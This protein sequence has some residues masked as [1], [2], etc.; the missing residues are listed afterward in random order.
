LLLPAVSAHRRLRGPYTAA[1]TIVRGL[2]ADALT[3]APE[4]VRAHEI[5]L[6]SVAPELRDVLPA[7]KETLTSLAVPEERTRFYSRLRTLRLAHGLTEFLRDYV[8]A[9]G[10]PATLMIDQADEADQTDAELIAVL[11]RRLRP[12]SLT[13]VIGTASEPPEQTGQ[14]STALARHAVRA[15]DREQQPDG[16]SPAVSTT[17]AELAVAYVA[18]D[19]TDDEP[20][21]AAGYAALPEPERAALHDARAAELS[22]ESAAELSVSLGAV[23]YHREH[24]GDPAG[25][26]A[27]ALRKALEYCIDMGFYEATVDLGKRGRAVIDW[28]AQRD[29]WWAFTTKMTTS[30]AALSRPVEAEELYDQARAFS[31]VPSVHMQA[32][33]ATAMLYTRHH[34]A[35][36]HDDNRALAWINE[37]IAIATLL[38]DKETRAMQTV[39]HHNGLALIKTRLGQHEEALRLVSGGLQ[40]LDA[41]L[42]PDQHRLHRSVLRY[43][44]AQLY[45]AM[46]R[47]DD[48]LTDYTAVIAAD[49]NYAEYHFDRAGLL[50]KLGRDDE[51]LTEYETA[52]RLTPPFP[53]LYYNRADLLAEL[54]DIDGALADFSYVIELD[55]EQ[56][57]AY[58]NR[59][60]L[61]AGRGE[62]TAARRDVATGL[63]LAPAD[64][65]LLCLLGQLDL[66]EGDLVAARTA[67]DAAVAAG[68]GVAQTW[69]ARAAVAFESGDLV[70]AVADLTTAIELSADPATLFNRG[71]IQ[72]T[73]HQWAVAEEDFSRALRYAPDDADTW[74]RRAQ[75]RHR[76][77]DTSGAAADL[78]QFALLAPDRTAEALAATDGAT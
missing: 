27:D 21:L 12:E 77:G 51:A 68:P 31:D 36:R 30:L 14:L 2:A 8:L 73:R 42:G 44:R 43:N 69:A 10:A 72:Q 23:P 66:A 39:F 5:E 7:T 17:A 64:P 40:R 45:V 61:L 24:G 78:H 32:A 15:A 18:S 46:G 48:A 65:H 37:A 70:A 26:G 19:C 50:R 56:T 74:L 67:L 58:L 63:S 6:L 34:D 57:D 1:G 22:S 28:V 55:P 62:L 13:L 75:C 38:P 25:A 54:G 16:T 9:V 11:L 20:E 29:H 60:D 76:L 41:D 4:L 3:V 53:E 35:D 49:P 47:L 59:A 52:M 33:Y 71:A